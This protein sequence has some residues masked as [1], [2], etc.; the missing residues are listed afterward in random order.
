[1]ILAPAILLGSF[2]SLFLFWMLWIIVMGFARAQAQ[3]RLSLTATVVG[4]VIEYAG[5]VWDVTCN[6]VICTALFLEVPFEPTL[7]QRLRRLVN[8]PPASA[9][10]FM[11]AYRCYKQALATWIAI[12]LVNP[13]SPDPASPHIPL[14]SPAA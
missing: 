12:N 4:T 2:G 1:M 5:L 6:V 7:S 9:N 10:R 8:T 13:F 3:G 11:Q 14:P